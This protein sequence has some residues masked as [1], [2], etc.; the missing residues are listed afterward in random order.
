MFSSPSRMMHKQHQ[1]AVSPLSQSFQN[2]DCLSVVKCLSL[3]NADPVFLF[4]ILHTL[5]SGSWPHL[6][7]PL[8]A[9]TQGQLPCVCG[10]AVQF[11][12]GSRKTAGV[13]SNDNL[14]LY[15]L[16]CVGKIT[17]WHSIKYLSEFVSPPLQFNMKFLDSLS[18]GSFFCV[19]RSKRRVWF[20]PTFSHRFVVVVPRCS[21]LRLNWAAI[22]LS[23]SR[24]NRNG[25]KWRMC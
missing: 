22:N 4:L 9:E 1:W 25:A 2:S 6:L 7:P 8:P 19:W 23:L 11:E 3:S 13:T 18:P 16:S 17:A 10:L 5:D 24:E 21:V 15:K 14:C 20:M 12:C